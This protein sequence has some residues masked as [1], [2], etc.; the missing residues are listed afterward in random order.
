[1]DD[2]SS[3]IE[4]RFQLSNDLC[5]KEELLEK[6]DGKLLTDI[7][8]TLEIVIDNQIFFFEKDIL[9]LELS[10]CLLHWLKRFTNSRVYDLIYETMDYDDEPL[11]VYKK[12]SGYEG[13]W[14]VKSPWGNGSFIL[15]ERTLINGTKNFVEEF[16]KTILK[17]FW[18]RIKNFG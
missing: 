14:I 13:T 9:L 6:K 12:I 18:L 1:M 2:I 8:G 11:L 10:V 17:K 16:D 3:K 7:Y 5:I 4:Y 15:E